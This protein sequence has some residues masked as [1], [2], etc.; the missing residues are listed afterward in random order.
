[1]IGKADIHRGRHDKD[2]TTIKFECPHV[3]LIWLIAGILSLGAGL[4]GV[5]LPL[6]PTVPFMLLAAF[7]FARSSERLH[8]WLVNHPRFGPQIVN[9]RAHGAISKSAKRLATFSILGAFAISLLLGLKPWILGVQAVTLAC[10]A[11]FIW[12]RPDQ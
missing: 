7:C 4:I 11:L 2:Q 8:D 1:M 3:R 9:W 5:F 6:I 10:V 12:S